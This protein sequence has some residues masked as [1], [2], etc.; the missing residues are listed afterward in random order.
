MSISKYFFFMK[1]PI[2]VVLTREKLKRFELRSAKLKRVKIELKSFFNFVFCQ[3]I[4]NKICREKYKDT[5][6]QLCSKISFKNK[7]NQ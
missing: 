6:F 2:S 4:N 5:V 1:L 3:E 7:E